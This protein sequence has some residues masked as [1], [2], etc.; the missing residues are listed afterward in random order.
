MQQQHNGHRPTQ[1]APVDL[2]SG[3]G[4]CLKEAQNA[5]RMAALFWSQFRY[6]ELTLGN[7]TC[8]YFLYILS[9]AADEKDN[10]PPQLVTR[11]V[12]LHAVSCESYYP[13]ATEAAG[14]T[15]VSRDERADVMY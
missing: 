14:N 13:P 1:T 15:T 7:C 5:E 11:D 8:W 9:D 6:E 3:K 4:A 12:K 10:D 2:L